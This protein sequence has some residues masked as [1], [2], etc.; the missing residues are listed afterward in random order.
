M[1]HIGTVAVSEQLGRACFSAPR[2][3]WRRGSRPEFYRARPPVEAQQSY[4]LPVF[5]GTR[6]VGLPRARRRRN[7]FARVSPVRTRLA[8]ES[9]RVHA[10]PRRPISRSIGIHTR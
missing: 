4:R 7:V 8:R 3:L 10:A 2:V 1:P 5:G 6:T 9:D